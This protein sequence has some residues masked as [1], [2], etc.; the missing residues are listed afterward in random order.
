VLCSAFAETIA[1]THWH[2]TQQIEWLEDKSIRFQC[3]VDGLE[4]IVWWVLSMGPYYQ[5]ESPPES[6]TW[7][8]ARPGPAGDLGD[9]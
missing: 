3:Q 7:P 4:E 6:A 2:S 9:C 5:V 1:D 8:S